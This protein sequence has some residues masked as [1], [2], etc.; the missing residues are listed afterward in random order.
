[1]LVVFQITF[2]YLNKVMYTEGLVVLFV[3]IS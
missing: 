2:E 1:M 3:F